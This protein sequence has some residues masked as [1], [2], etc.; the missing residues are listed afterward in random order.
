MTAAST[1]GGCNL[2]LSR[3]AC[4]RGRHSSHSRTGTVGQSSAGREQ[5]AQG[6]ASYRHSRHAPTPRFTRFTVET[7]RVI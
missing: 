4:C 2:V 5:S 7:P 6:S 3:V 1:R